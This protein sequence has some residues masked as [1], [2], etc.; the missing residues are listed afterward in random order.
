MIDQSGCQ[1]GA[2]E[3]FFLCLIGALYTDGCSTPR[4]RP[5]LL[6]TAIWPRPRQRLLVTAIWPASGEAYELMLMH[7]FTAGPD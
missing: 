2:G 3:L 5:Q 6:V 7:C 1:G 4:P